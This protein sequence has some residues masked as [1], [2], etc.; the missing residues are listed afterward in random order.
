MGPPGPSERMTVCR[1]RVTRTG[2]YTLAYTKPLRATSCPK[3]RLCN[4]SITRGT[5][6]DIGSDSRYATG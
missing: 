3:S 2:V 5:P 1:L 4:N 6:I